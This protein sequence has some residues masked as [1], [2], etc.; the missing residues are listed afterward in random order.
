[1]SNRVV[2]GARANG[3]VGLFV[4]PPGV[5]AMTAPDSALLLS[6]TAK[7]S[8]LILMGRVTSSQIVALGLSALCIHYQRVRLV[9]CRR[10]RAGAKAVSPVAAD[11]RCRSIK[12]HDQQQWRVDEPQRQFADQVS[13]LQPGVLM[14]RRVILDSGAASPLKI[15]VAG[16]DAATAHSTAVFSTATSRRYGS[17][18][19]ASQRLAASHGV[20]A[21]SA[22]T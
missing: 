7:V 4:A 9:G 22:R 5:N 2:L 18:V 17:G 6:A 19:R 14:A 10:S 8:Q 16:V 11:R 1:M 21:S 13:G 12:L 3:D 20:S 15:S